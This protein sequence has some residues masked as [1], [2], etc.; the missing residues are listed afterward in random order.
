VDTGRPDS[1]V[2]F[3]P[4]REDLGPRPRFTRRQVRLARALD[5]LDSALEIQDLLDWLSEPAGFS[6]SVGR[7]EILGRP[8]GLGRAGMN[9]VL[10]WPRLSTRLGLGL[11][12]PLAH[13]LVDRLL[14]FDR[15]LGEE[16]L[17]ITPVEW[18]I[19]S[20]AVAGT[21]THMMK[22]PGPLGDWDLVIDRVGSDAFSTDG[23]GPMTTIRWPMTVEGTDGSL[24]LW[25]PDSVLDAWLDALPESRP[26]KD[27]ESVQERYADLASE[28]R[29]E[30]GSI[31]LSDGLSALRE[32]GIF[33]IDGSPLRGSVE[34]PEGP[35]SLV[36][37]DP[38]G[39]L[40]LRAEPDPQ[41]GAAR[42][43]V[44]PPVVRDLLPRESASMA[45]ADPSAP[46]SSASEL[47][48]SLTVELGRLSLPLGRLAELKSGD[49]V[50]LSRE[51]GAPVD[52]TSGGRLVARG[53]LV[54]IDDELGV[55][56]TRVF[57]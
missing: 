6:V 24:R 30:A 20:F 33:P 18:G 26:A 28:W 32:G 12:T 52:L 35:V 11:E 22:A 41:S 19:L 43:I 2:E 51:P 42:L 27:L 36:L 50:E 34:S 57:V 4:E 1:E 9:A 53:E 17:Q 3:D 15:R 29:A 55:R 16:R 23:L 54:E 39:R 40:S 25:V 13:A 37:R 46:V 38:D 5:R 56:V 48:V 10:A 49:I 14:G 31:M 47:P 44:Y 7:P 21:L 45:S 8:S